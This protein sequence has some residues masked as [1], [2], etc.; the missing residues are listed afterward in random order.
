MAY[1]FYIIHSSVDPNLVNYNNERE[2]SQ[3]LEDNDIDLI[4]KNPNYGDLI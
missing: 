3:Y 1:I 4:D 2:L